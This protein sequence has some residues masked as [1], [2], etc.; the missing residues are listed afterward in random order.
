MPTT[1]MKSS[2]AAKACSVEGPTSA[3]ELSIAS[4][5]VAAIAMVTVEDRSTVV[6]IPW[7]IK[8]PPKGIPQQPITG[9]PGIAPETGV[10]IPTW[11]DAT[12][13]GVIRSQIDISLGQ[14]LRAQAAP[15]VE[16]VFGLIAIETS[17][18]IVSLAGQLDLAVTLYLE[19]PSGYRL[20]PVAR[21]L[22]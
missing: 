12:I 1:A 9:Q 8:A 3:V 4:S 11:S 14:I 5:I 10:P 16:R 2:A 19:S 13:T 17:A 21:P 18:L 22:P 20:F 15:V 7:R 6:D